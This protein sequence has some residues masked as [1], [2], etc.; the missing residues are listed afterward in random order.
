MNAMK[1]LLRTMAIAA[2]LASSLLVLPAMAQET[3]KVGLIL[4]LTG[5]FAP[6]GPIYRAVPLTN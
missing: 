1:A 4:P 2:P 3:V 5:P 6:T